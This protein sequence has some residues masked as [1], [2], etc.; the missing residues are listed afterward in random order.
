MKKQIL[1]ICAPILITLAS[2]G[3]DTYQ[4]KYQKFE[5]EQKSDFE[6]LQKIL[7]ETTPTALILYEGLPH[8]MWEKQSLEK[9]LREKKTIRIDGY[10]FYEETLEVKDQDLRT[11]FSQLKDSKNFQPYAGPKLCG[12]YHPDYCLRVKT[13][14]KTLDIQVCFG[15]HEM[16]LLDG[17]KKYIWDMSKGTDEKLKKTI[18]VYRKNRPVNTDEN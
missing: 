11:I 13:P 9:E 14:T 3:E 5:K 8:Q 10:P 18:G 16:V 6:T 4:E 12:G 15:C 17:S 1:L 7:L 2:S